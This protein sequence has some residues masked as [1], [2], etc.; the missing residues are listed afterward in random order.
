MLMS[1]LKRHIVLIFS[2][3]GV[4]QFLFNTVIV[5]SLCF[6]FSIVPVYAIETGSIGTN[7]TYTLND[8]DVLT[9]NGVGEIVD[10]SVNDS[11]TMLPASVK[12]S[13]KKIV[14]EDGIT[15]IGVSA[16]SNCKE[17]VEVVMPSSLLFIEDRAFNSCIN[18]VNVSLPESLKEIGPRA[19]ANCKSL[20]FITIPSKATLGQGVF[21]GC[22]GLKTAGPI[23]GDYNI[24]FAWA[25]SI[26]ALAF[27]NNAYL[28]DIFIPNNIKKIGGGAFFGCSSLIHITIPNSVTEI[29]GIGGSLFQG[30]GLRTAGPIG[31]GYDYE[32]GWETAIPDWAFYGC[33][34]LRSVSMPETI[35]TIGKFAFMDCKK[36][37]ELK[38]PNYLKML[39]EYSFAR[40]VSLNSVL[41][42]SGVHTLP[43]SVFEG[44]S[45]LSSITVS[46]TLETIDSTAF[47][48]CYIEEV[49]YSGSFSDWR[50]VANGSTLSSADIHFDCIAYY[51]EEP[52]DCACNSGEEVAMFINNSNVDSFQWQYSNDNGST[53]INCT[54]EGSKT[55][56]FWF[57]AKPVMN[58]RLYRCIVSSDQNEYISR[59]ALLTVFSP[60]SIST[61]PQSIK[62]SLGSSKT[63]KV[64]A[65]GEGLEYQWYYSKNDGASWTKW[66]GRTS[67]SLKLTASTTNNGCLYRCVISNP[68]G[69]VTSTSAKLT[70]SGL[71]AGPKITSQPD[72]I[73]A[74]NGEMASFK[75]SASGTGLKYRW[76]LSKNGGSTWTNCT[77]MTSDTDTFTFKAASSYNG[78]MYRCRV[79]DASGKSVFSEAVELTVR[80]AGPKITSQP[81]DVIAVDGETAFFNVSASGNGLKY[82][83][84]LSKNGG[85]T[86]INCTAATSD[87]DT[88]TFKAATSY[89]GRMYR[90]RVTDASGNRVFSET[91]EL[92]V[93]AAGPKITSQ[94]E[95]QTVSAGA[96][97]TFSVTASGTGLEY[98]WQYSKN[99]TSW[100]DCSSAGS[101][102]ASFSFKAGTVHSGRLYRCVVSDANGNTVSQGARL[103]VE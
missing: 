8:A 69:S 46:D 85:S 15:S 13:V 66:S 101:D 26:P 17:L 71:P 22:A 4:T 42:P 86:W 87:T 64:I 51:S 39:G 57:I 30:T 103:T 92:T 44:C 27:S 70:V 33:D 60:P 49:Y 32:Y 52:F 62:I 102:T 99:G 90:C 56:T 79:T 21:S 59:F 100:T 11:S 38:L 83:W 80:A 54:S 18:M 67:S 74:V 3:M 35:K 78:R 72:D 25:D 84:Q 43:Q 97:V 95:A 63:I 28:V 75:V 31:G 41:I 1:I 34:S 9:I 96:R 68:A 48:G 53:W 2:M 98:Q 61:Q 29:D 23:G 20:E 7:I 50:Q 65:S 40:C 76:Q 89:S 10:V 88:F 14:I 55:D 81:D 93:R 58:G 12:N 6:L 5:F 94:P 24:E 45:G 37:S 91:A 73:I 16:F 82:Q 77:A 19:F 36:L 47:S